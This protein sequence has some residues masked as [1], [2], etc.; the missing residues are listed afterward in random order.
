MT[1]YRPPLDAVT[2]ALR[3]LDAASMYGYTPSAA[4]HAALV[5]LGSL[6]GDQLRGVAA[7][8]ATLATSFAR[9]ETLAWR[10]RAKVD[11]DTWLTYT[12]CRI[13][14]GDEP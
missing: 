11:L 3:V 4:F 13:A 10:Y 12:R 7:A 1:D 5:H 8:V 14:D 2:E 6:D 9:L